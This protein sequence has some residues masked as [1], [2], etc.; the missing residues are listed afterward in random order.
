M[1]FL[2]AAFHPRDR[3]NPGLIATGGQVTAQTLLESYRQGIFPWYNAGEPIRWWSPDPRAILELDQFHISHRLARRIRS[4]KFRCTM[5]QAFLSVVRG[6][7]Q[8]DEETWITSAM[9]SAYAELHRAGHAHSI[10]VC[11]AINSPA[12]S[13]AW[14]WAGSSRVSRCSTASEMPRRWRS[15]FSSAICAREAVN[16]STCK[17]APITR[18][19]WA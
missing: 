10:E 6:C 5:D 15:L 9:I 13:S 11:K 18:H 4:G 12:A 19:L 7:A 17:F 16:S 8:R 2:G 3:H 1:P 14:A